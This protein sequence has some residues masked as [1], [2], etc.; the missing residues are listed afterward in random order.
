MAE[1]ILATCFIVMGLAALAASVTGYRG[2]VGEQYTL[3]ARVCEDP[4]LIRRA[5]RLVMRW[6]FVASVMSI[7][8]VA[9]IWHG[10]LGGGDEGPS[11]WRVVL[12]AIYGN[13]ALA[14]GSYPFARISR[15]LA[16]DTGGSQ[17]HS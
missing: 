3:P 5:N 16:H 9:L 1:V 2:E 7:P 14:V 6:C 15:F 13:V 10:E 4:V 8:P 17:S 11:L 12:F